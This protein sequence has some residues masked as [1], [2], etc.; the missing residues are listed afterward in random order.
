[1]LASGTSAGF[2]ELPETIRKS[3]GVSQSS[4]A[5]EIVSGGVFAMI[6][7]SGMEEMNGAEA[8]RPMVTPNEALA[9]PPSVSVTAIVILAQPTRLVVVVNVTVRLV[10]LPPNTMPVPGTRSGFKE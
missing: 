5:T 4:T 8:R 6:P 1:M 7:R 10:P 9:V 2:D 3:A